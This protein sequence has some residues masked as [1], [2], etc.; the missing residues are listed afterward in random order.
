MSVAR[1]TGRLVEVRT[2]APLL[3]AE[4]EPFVKRFATL[5]AEVKGLLV[6][7]GDLGASPVLDGPTAR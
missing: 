5:L 7:S 4:V 3:D 1:T 2:T 6:A